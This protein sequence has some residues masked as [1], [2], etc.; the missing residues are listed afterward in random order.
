MFKMGGFIHEVKRKQKCQSHFVIVLLY[1]SYCIILYS[2]SICYKV[3]QRI[4]KHFF[5]FNSIN[6][7]WTLL[8]PQNNFQ[9][10]SQYIIGIMVGIAKTFEKLTL[11]VGKDEKE[12][13]QVQILCITIAQIITNILM[14]FE[15]STVFGSYMNCLV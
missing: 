15:A 3:S 4:S 14:L 6:S 13:N 12:C 10:H 7:H 2:C 9:R 11:A 1:A 8:S 5:H